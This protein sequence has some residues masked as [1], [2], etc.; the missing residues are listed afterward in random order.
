M[1]WQSKVMP[2]DAPELA[3]SLVGTMLQGDGGNSKPTPNQ[4]QIRSSG[5]DDTAEAHLQSQAGIV[6]GELRAARE[7]A[8]RMGHEPTDFA[9]PY[10][11]MLHLL[12][13]GPN[14]KNQQ[15]LSEKGEPLWLEIANAPRHGTEILGTDYDS[16]EIIHWA[17]LNRAWVTRD[18]DL[19][20]PS[21]WQPL[22]D[23]PD[24]PELA[25]RQAGPH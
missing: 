24:H 14:H 11:L 23:Q 2:D 6:L 8:V 19:F 13:E 12:Y 10:L 15:P 9:A 7:L 22:P 16:I 21:F 25:R 5:K 1:T 20:F 17:E 3:G 18:H 4:R